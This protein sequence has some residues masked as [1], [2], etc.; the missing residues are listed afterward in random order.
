LTG[1]REINLFA[2]KAQTQLRFNFGLAE[3]VASTK[4]TN[5]PVAS[6][7]RQAEKAESRRNKE[8]DFRI[9]P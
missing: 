1:W 9:T 3:F 8:L 4:V 7:M 5:F 6:P 2:G